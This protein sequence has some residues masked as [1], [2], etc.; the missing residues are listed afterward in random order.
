[1][2]VNPLYCDV[3][4]P[5]PLDQS[6]TYG[7]PETL[8]H[9]V[10]PGCRV[11]APFGTRTLTGLVIKTHSDPPKGALRDILR[12]LDEEPALDAELLQLGKWI[13]DFYCAPLG[14][15]LRAMTP[16]AGEIRRGKMYSLTKSG[17]DVARQLAPRLRRGRRSRS[18]SAPHAGRTPALGIVSKA[19]NPKRRSSIEIS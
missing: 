19:E 4:L 14:E 5:V 10:Q 15:T 3:S 17:R 7:M 9:R 12:L 16:L 13:A 8:R 11:L 18:H 6:F 2:P 1:M